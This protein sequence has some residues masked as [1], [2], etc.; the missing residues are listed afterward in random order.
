LI[1]FHSLLKSNHPEAK[2]AFEEYSKTQNKE[3]FYGKILSLCRAGQT[4]PNEREANVAPNKIENKRICYLFREGKCRRNGCKFE[5]MLGNQQTAPSE[6]LG[7]KPSSNQEEKEPQIEKKESKT[8]CHFIQSNGICRKA[9]KCRFL[10]PLSVREGNQWKAQKPSEAKSAIP[11]KTR[12]E[13]KGR[14]IPTEEEDQAINEREIINST[15]PPP[16]PA[17]GHQNDEP[18]GRSLLQTSD[19]NHSTSPQAENQKVPSEMELNL[20]AS[21]A[22]GFHPPPSSFARLTDLSV[23][24]R[25]SNL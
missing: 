6:D 2:I 8:I 24:R 3:Q 18:L 23:R 4:I 25:D 17:K 13:T 19:L 15:A 20:D 21:T 22:P 5:H 16:A 11:S 14:P 7:S 9:D 10:H 1:V 12:K